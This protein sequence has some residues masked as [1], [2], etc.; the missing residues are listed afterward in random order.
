M[1][2]TDSEIGDRTVRD[3]TLG[4]LWEGRTAPTRGPKPALSIVRIADAAMRIADAEGLAAV[5]MQ[6]VAAEL[7]DRKSVV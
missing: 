4:L 5:S 7:E 2:T 6:R 1:T 3:E